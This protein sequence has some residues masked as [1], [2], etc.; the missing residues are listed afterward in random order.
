MESV[1]PKNHNDEPNNK[2]N[3]LGLASEEE[4]KEYQK[5]NPRH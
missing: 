2:G 3:N 5:E 1:A 4:W